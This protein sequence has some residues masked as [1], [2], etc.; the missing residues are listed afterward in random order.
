MNAWQGFKEGRWTNEIDVRGF[1]PSKLHS[2]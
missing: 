2:I 1:H